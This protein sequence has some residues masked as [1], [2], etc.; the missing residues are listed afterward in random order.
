MPEV[1]LQQ[2][3]LEALASDSRV[4]ILKDLRDRQKTLTQIA[5]SVGLD[6][7]TV[8]RHLQRL[9]E[10]S[11]VHRDD[12]H[13]FTYYRLTFQGRAVVVPRETTRIAIVLGS[14]VASAVAA[15]ASLS[16][17]LTP[18]FVREP[19]PILDQV[20]WVRLPSEPVFLAAAGILLALVG[21][22]G[23]AMG[24]SLRPPRLRLTQAERQDETAPIDR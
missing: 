4:T 17:Y 9:V 7:G 6:K 23:F 22:L 13:S 20:R 8:Y 2:K 19:D 5:R 11:L 16:V 12:A 18:R 14:A 15:F 3:A 24:R 10:G 21:L 1:V